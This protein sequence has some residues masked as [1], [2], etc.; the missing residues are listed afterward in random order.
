M[1]ETIILRKNLKSVVVETELPFLHMNTV[2]TSK[3]HSMKKNI[4]GPAG[5]PTQL[6]AIAVIRKK[7]EHTLP[8]KGRTGIRHI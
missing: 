7:K 1:K 2:N 6:S 5:D 3:K 8:Q 4:F